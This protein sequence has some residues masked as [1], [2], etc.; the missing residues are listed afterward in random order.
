[1][2]S[3]GSFIKP[4]SITAI[5]T[6]AFC[7][8]HAFASENEAENEAE[9]QATEPQA[10]REQ[11]EQGRWD[12]RRF[13]L[14]ENGKWSVGMGTVVS[15]SPF[16]GEK[17]TVTP[18][19]IIDYSSKNLFIRGLR[20]GFH[21]QKVANPREGGFF[22]DVFVSPRI[23]PGDSRR[24]ISVDGG[25]SGGYQSIAGTITLSLLQD[26]SGLNDG[27]ELN[28]SYSFPYLTSGKKHFFLPK[29]EITYQ[30]EDLANYLWGIDTETYQKTL[31]NPEEV[32][33]QPYTLDSST[34]NYSASM[35][36]IFRI[37]ENW[38]TLSM[39]KITSLG[40]DITDNPAVERQFD[41][42]FIFGF[43]Y[44]F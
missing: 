23:R 22:A 36:H 3:K 20:A 32:V 37:T 40:S 24:K 15:N 33:L 14:D 41:Y 7:G 29:L 12:Y 19:P 39:A 11:D 13:L 17:I 26:I 6:I 25:L 18:I 35:T 27:M 43:A 28:L 44:T 16:R 38:N 21:L 5:S 42:S 8:S 34:F 30:S 31:A 4:L 1:M 10:S 2:T 9:N